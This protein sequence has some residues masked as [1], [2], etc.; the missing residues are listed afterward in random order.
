M[1]TASYSLQVN[2]EIPHVAFWEDG[3][4]RANLVIHHFPEE[5]SLLIWNEA[6]KRSGSIMENQHKTQTTTSHNNGQ[7]HNHAHELVL[8][9]SLYI[10]D[11][12]H[13]KYVCVP[14]STCL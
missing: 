3:G 10:R 9:I 2:N 11:I 14:C 1:S 13:S 12:F 4:Q 8:L 5:Y 7:T 6:G